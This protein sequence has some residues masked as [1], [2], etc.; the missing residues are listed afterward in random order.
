MVTVP[1]P[2]RVAI[3]TRWQLVEAINRWLQTVSQGSPCLFR[4]VFL[5]IHRPRVTCRSRCH[6][7]LYF[8]FLLLA[9]NLLI[10]SGI[11]MIRF[12]MRGN[13]FVYRYIQ[14]AADFPIHSGRFAKK[15]FALAQA[16]RMKG[17]LLAF[18][19]R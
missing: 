15:L 8:F 6:C 12:V 4:P 10:L 17:R 14:K 7:Q 9:C 16:A 13:Q 3:H 2:S 18:C 5:D 19:P 11:L 1:Y